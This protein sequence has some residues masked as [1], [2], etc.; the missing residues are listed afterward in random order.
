MESSLR[1][2]RLDV[3]HVQSTYI[4]IYREP[5]DK[6]MEISGFRLKPVERSNCVWE[7]HHPGSNERGRLL[8]V[9]GFLTEELVSM[10]VKGTAY[11]VTRQDYTLALLFSSP[12]RAMWLSQSNYKVLPKD[13]A[14]ICPEEWP[15]EMVARVIRSRFRT[16]LVLDEAFLLEKIGLRPPARN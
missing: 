4:G 8:H 2:S 3:H 12:A 1:K 16:V 7:F 13:G 15:R 14:G 11:M 6:V 5:F 9:E 10:S